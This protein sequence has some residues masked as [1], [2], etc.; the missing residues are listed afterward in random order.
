MHAQPQASQGP[1]DGNRYD[2]GEEQLRALRLLSEQAA[3]PLDQLAR[4]LGLDLAQTVRL[5]QRL[6]E[7][8]LIETRRFLVRDY[9]WLWPSRRGATRAGTGFHYK[10]PDVAMLAHR[11]AVNEIRLHLAERA[12]RGVWVCERAV[13]NRRDPEDHLPDAVFETDGERHAIEAELSRKTN[14]QIR[15]IVAQHSNRYDAVIYFCGP[16]P[17]NLL[18]RVQAEGRWPKLIVR[19]LP[20][21]EPC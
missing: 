3:I 5:A 19:R 9:P 15:Q 4:L 17:Y 13:F 11:R 21:G 18:K 12:P 14:R 1:Q 2:A 16:H 7:E 6:E 8:R 10:A 20:E